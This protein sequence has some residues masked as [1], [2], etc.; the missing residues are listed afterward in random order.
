M[1]T[2]SFDYQ[3]IF[4]RLYNF[5]KQKSEHKDMSPY[6]TNVLL[7]EDLATEMAYE[8]LY[9][10]Y[11]TRETKWSL[12]RNISSLVTQSLFHG[13]KIPRKIG[14]KGTC[15]LSISEDFDTRPNNNIPIPRF[16]TFST[17]DD[18]KIVSIEDTLYTTNEDYCDV[19]VSQGIFRSETFE[20]QGQIFEEFII[21]NNKIDND[22]IY[23]YVNNILV[24]IVDSLYDIDANKYY[25][26]I[27]T[28]PDLSGI[29][30]I[31]GN[32][33][34][35]KQLLTNDTIYIQ[36]IETE[37][38]EGNL[39]SDNLITIA[40]SNIYDIQ[41][42]LVD[43]YVTNID[44]LVGGVNEI[45]IEKLRTI[46]PRFYQSGNRAGTVSD[47][48]TLLNN[49]PYIKKATVWGSY[50]IN[51][52]LNRD[53]WEYISSED[54]IVHISAVNDMGEDLTREQKLQLVED[55]YLRKPPTDILEYSDLSLINLK[56]YITGY[57]DDRSKT[58]LYMSSLIK[59]TLKNTYKIDNFDFKQNVYGSDVYALIDNLPGIRYAN[60]TIRI[61]KRFTFEYEYVTSL[62]VDMIPVDFTI[63]KFFIKHI[64]E[65]EFHPIAKVLVNGQI[66]GINGYDTT[67]SNISLS[68]GKILFTVT[69]I[70]D[71]PV[72][73][74]DLYFEYN[75]T[76]T[77]NI[78]LTSRNQ[79]ISYYDSEVDCIYYNRS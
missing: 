4:N 15:R 32:G 76:N 45:D 56:F 22:I 62:K 54:N 36:Y 7:L 48:H 78:I 66:E 31:F 55:I 60:I 79:I 65:D 5:L 38:K 43:L 64:S 71:R 14:A 35:G 6:G 58:L 1:A 20:A 24:T 21:S 18:I 10:E 72:N 42:R 25:C 8:M 49:I 23:I 70:L 74:Y 9:D 30:I 46:S 68:S 27:D 47:Y 33:V 44:P 53:P 75:K 57:V 51:L 2:V 73:E 63:S 39:L 37:G 50:E 59:E 13:F 3:S 17:E 77:E 28:L 16:T 34:F 29:K 12:A 26:Q 67:G 52:D 11:A 19:K 61:L 69:N 41:G 40:D